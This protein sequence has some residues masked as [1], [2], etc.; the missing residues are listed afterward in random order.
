MIENMN[1]EDTVKIMKGLT[2]EG[3]TGVIQKI[4]PWNLDSPHKE[5]RELH[6]WLILED[7]IEY[8][9]HGSLLEPV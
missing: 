3:Q 1:V 9:F 6:Y 5:L 7:G 4:E 8:H 2:G